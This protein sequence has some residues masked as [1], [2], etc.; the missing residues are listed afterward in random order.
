MKHSCSPRVLHRITFVIRMRCPASLRASQ[1][2]VR[3]SVV[4]VH[5]VPE[6]RT[7]S[8]ELG[9]RGLAV[10]RKSSQPL[11]SGSPRAGKAVPLGHATGHGGFD[12]VMTDAVRCLCRE[13]SQHEKDNCPRKLSAEAFFPYILICQFVSIAVGRKY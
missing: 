9:V 8:F 12:P 4:Q 1:D 13:S 3:V 2:T 5:T 11:L 7:P 6:Q 10:C